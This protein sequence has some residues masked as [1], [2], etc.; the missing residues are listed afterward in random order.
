VFVEVHCTVLCS[1]MIDAVC[2][3]SELLSIV[4]KCVCIK[5][6]ESAVHIHTCI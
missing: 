1:I 6:I 3:C 4:L 2:S 5:I